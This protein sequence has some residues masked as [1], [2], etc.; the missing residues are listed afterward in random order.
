MHR[1]H[2]RECGLSEGL[3]QFCHRAMRERG[4]LFHAGNYRVDADVRFLPFFLASRSIALIHLRNLQNLI[5]TE[6]QKN[7]KAREFPTELTMS[8]QYLPPCND[9]ITG[10]LV[11]GIEVRSLA[12]NT[13]RLRE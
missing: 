10:K 3:V 7:D 4:V 1:Y 12:I 11:I 9:V 2:Q 5:Q 8:L 6:K 13:F